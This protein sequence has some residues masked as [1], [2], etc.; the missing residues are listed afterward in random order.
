MIELTVALPMFRNKS[1]G[2][3]ALESLVRQKNINFEWELL[4]MEEAQDCVGEEKIRE[5]VPALE[6]IGC[7]RIKY[8]QI[9]T[10]IPLSQKWQ[11]LATAASDTSQSF[12]IQ[13]ADCFSQ[14]YRL[15]ETYDL[16]AADANIDWVQSPQGYFYD[17][18][19]EAVALFSKA[20]FKK[21]KW[22]KSAQN[23][24]CAL[25]MSMRTKYARQL[26][27]AQVKSSVDSWLF[28]SCTTIKGSPLNVGSID[29]ENWKLGVDVH[30]VNKISIHRG[31]RIA[32]STPPFQRDEDVKL[33]D[34]VP[35]E[36]ALMIRGLKSEISNNKTIYSKD[37]KV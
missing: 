17:I 31:S 32:K 24:P 5:Y 23:H 34:L 4:I 7:K 37:K 21:I 10:W 13:A 35:E 18:N 28:K 12:L 14:P 6:K 25:N 29:S 15:R 36:I 2:H 3:L 30:G 9:P 33:D 26:P 11:K 16:Y 19:S 20:F 1:I 22:S 27:E 8:W